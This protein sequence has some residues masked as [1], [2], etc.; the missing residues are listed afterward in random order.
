VSAAF[1][2]YSKKLLGM[3]IEVFV[4]FNALELHVTKWAIFGKHR[5]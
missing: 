2:A 3:G 1:S 5:W 4:Q